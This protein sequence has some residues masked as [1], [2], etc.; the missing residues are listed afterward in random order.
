[1]L[2][3]KTITRILVWSFIGLCIVISCFFYFFGD[4]NKLK[5]TVESNLKNQLS[6]TVKLGDL[7]WDLDGFRLGVT[8]SKITLYD[9]ENNIVLQ[10]GPTRFVWHLKNIIIGS[11]SHFYSIDSTKLYL[12]AIRNKKGVWNLVEMFPTGPPPKVDNL[13][14]HNSILYVIDE[15]NPVTQKI[16]YKDFN[17]IFE[18]N[19]FSRMKE[20][21]VSLF[22]LLNQFF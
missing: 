3:L 11:Y 13:R 19:L 15:L 21:E 20:F 4:I 10:G 7:D 14:L 2:S 6:C 9:N 12:N 8:T 18:K 22:L 5:S 1:M 16:L 17:V